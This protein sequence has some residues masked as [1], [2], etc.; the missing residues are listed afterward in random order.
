MKKKLHDA[1]ICIRPAVVDGVAL[2][3]TLGPPIY[4]G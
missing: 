4:E 2:R 3:F 1:L